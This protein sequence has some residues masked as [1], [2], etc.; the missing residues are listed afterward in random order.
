MFKKEEKCKMSQIKIYSMVLSNQLNDVNC[1]YF[2]LG[3]KS[4]LLFVLRSVS[5]EFGNMY[6]NTPR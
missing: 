1:I 2:E 4:K 5:S 6:K 3:F